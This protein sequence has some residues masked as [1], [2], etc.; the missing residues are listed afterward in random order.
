MRSIL[1]T[2]SIILEGKCEWESV[3]TLNMV[4]QCLVDLTKGDFSMKFQKVTESVK[5]R[6]NSK[7]KSYAQADFYQIK[8]T[9][10]LKE[11]NLCVCAYRS[12]WQTILIFIYKYAY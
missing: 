6:E 3:E 7:D 1:F 2:L 5:C 11:P 8:I 9:W 4:S 10:L 12:I